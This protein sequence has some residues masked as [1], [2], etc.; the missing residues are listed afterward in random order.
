MDEIFEYL[1]SFKTPDEVKQECIRLGVKGK[2]SRC[3]QCVIVRLIEAKFPHVANERILFR[4]S[5]YLLIGEKF[6][7]PSDAVSQLAHQFD[8]RMHKELEEE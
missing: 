2:P 4:P 1:H 3:Q 5:R 7:A 8:L 6:Y